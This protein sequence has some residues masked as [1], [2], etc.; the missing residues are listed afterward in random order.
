MK[1]IRLPV[2]FNLISFSDIEHKAKE[3]IPNQASLKPEKHQTELHSQSIVSSESSLSTK[4][5]STLLVEEKNQ[6]EPLSENVTHATESLQQSA[7]T[8]E[9]L[10]NKSNEL[11]AI[12][13]ESIKSTLYDRGKKSDD[14]ASDDQM[15]KES[16]PC[17]PV[18]IKSKS[19]SH[20]GP[21]SRFDPETLHLIREIGSALMNSPAKSELEER[22]DDEVQ[23]GES[24]VNFFVRKIEKNIRTSK[25][26]KKREIVI[27][28]KSTCN[29][30]GSDDNSKIPSDSTA[31]QQK[32]SVQQS[33]CDSNEINE[34]SIY[35]LIDRGSPVA[36]RNTFPSSFQF[37]QNVSPKSER[38][39]VS[40]KWSPNAKRDSVF[41]KCDVGDEQGYGKSH[42]LFRTAEIT[43]NIDSMTDD[44][45][46]SLLSVNLNLGA[47]F[48]KDVGELTESEG[49]SVKSL[50]DKFTAKSTASSASVVSTSDIVFVS[51]PTTTI[52][53][54]SVKLS[55][56][57]IKATGAAKSPPK[58]DKP[59]L[60]H[61][62]SEPVIS[63][64]EVSL[65]MFSKTVGSYGLEEK[66]VLHEE[67]EVQSTE[68]PQE[69]VS[70]RLEPS[71]TTEKN[72]DV[73]TFTGDSKRT[74]FRQK[75]TRSECEGSAVYPFE[76]RKLRTR[77][78]YGKSHPLAKLE[79][80]NSMRT[81]P[82]YSTM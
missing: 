24:R 44:S 72:S 33:I 10:D 76:E 49:C 73:S 13:I 79:P 80:R 42:D 68:I 11:A 47:D 45:A 54:T 34:A 20:S 2:L 53:D 21:E 23:E 52:A 8:V 18:N 36:R 31:E 57:M 27:I 70:D 64:S 7:E 12:T 38:K 69:N 19:G 6:T 43:G 1:S 39:L 22:K 29:L 26:K 9:K 16:I 66:D 5:V 56:H 37:D 48:S 67:V 63:L 59:P 74:A 61:R 81:N 30:K 41:E 55:G 62:Q 50:V 46:Q 65:Q 78:T 3:I 25:K 32:H 51:S 14:S 40:V 71:K 77:K 17:T 4:Q 82:F 58:H 28:E 60:K 35:S 15:S 75:Q